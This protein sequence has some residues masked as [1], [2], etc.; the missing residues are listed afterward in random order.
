MGVDNID[1][2]AAGSAGIMVVNAP[3]ASTQSVVELT[4]GHLC[5]QSDIYQNL[6]EVCAKIW[7]RKR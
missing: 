5:L 7:K 6:I 1:L 3:N 4:I 2:E